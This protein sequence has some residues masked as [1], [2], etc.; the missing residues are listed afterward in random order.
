[1]WQTEP[2]HCQWRCYLLSRATV[3]GAAKKG[4]SGEIV[5]PMVYFLRLYQ[6]WVN[7]V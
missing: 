5:S 7:F 3:S 2:R 4:Y 6:V 1:M